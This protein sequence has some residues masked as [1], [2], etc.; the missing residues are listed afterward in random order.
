MPAR[1]WGQSFAQRATLL[2]RSDRPAL[3]P[4]VKERKEGGRPFDIAV[5]TMSV[6][7]PSKSPDGFLRS[8]RQSSFSQPRFESLGVFW[9]PVGPEQHLSQIGNTLIGIELQNPCYRLLR[10]L[11]M[12]GECIARGANTQRRQRVRSTPQCLSR[13]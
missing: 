7:S 13:P 1:G 6:G 10:P 3:A 5:R 4:S 12:P 11:P 2:P 9:P 8:L